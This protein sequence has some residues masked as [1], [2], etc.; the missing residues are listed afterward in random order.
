M[1]TYGLQFGTY[2]FP[3]TLTYNDV[4]LNS[5]VSVAKLPRADGSRILP[6]TLT[7][8]RITI[9]GSLLKT[10]TS[11]LRDQLDALKAAMMSGPQNLYF[12]SDRYLRNCQKDPYGES[13]GMTWPERIV[14]IS[15][16]LVTGDPFFYEVAVN[17]ATQAV[18]AC[19]TTWTVTAGGNAYALPQF[20]ITVGSVVSGAIAF[21]IT[22]ETTG[23][24]FTLT[25]AANVGD[26]IIVDSLEET[27]TISGVDRTDLFDGLFPRLAVGA[28]T[29]QACYSIGSI[30]SVSIVWQNRWY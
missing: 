6:G 16:G 13:Y 17:T 23:E 20:Q 7:E 19:P 28:N 10:P 3:G 18:S 9:K 26:V 14:D 25:G 5:Q 29:I 2:T 1:A 22:N 24:A 4:P 27:V 15:L 11:P 30:S 12:N 21:T 8:R